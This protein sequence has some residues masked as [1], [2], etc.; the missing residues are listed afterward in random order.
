MFNPHTMAGEEKSEL[1][2][3]NSMSRL[4]EQ[5]QSEDWA[6]MGWPRTLSRAQSFLVRAPFGDTHASKPTRASSLL[7]RHGP[8]SLNRGYF[9]PDAEPLNRQFVYQRINEGS[10][11]PLQTSCALSTSNN[12]NYSTHASL[13]AAK[14][15]LRELAYESGTG[16]SRGRTALPVRS[17]SQQSFHLENVPEES[18]SDLSKGGTDCN[19]PRTDS[20]D[21][22]RAGKSTP[23]Q[24]AINMT[25]ILCGSGL[26]ALPYAT[27]CTSGYVGACGLLAM[28][29]AGTLFTAKL[30]GSELEHAWARQP[31]RKGFPGFPDL[32]SYAFGR[33]GRIAVALAL[34]F[35]LFLCL[36][37]FLLM[38][39]ANISATLDAI[40]GHPVHPVDADA[41][42]FTALATQLMTPVGCIWIMTAILVP[43][44]TFDDLTALSKFSAVGTIA[45]LALVLVVVVMALFC[46]GASE[47]LRLHNQ[48]N[49]MLGSN[50]DVSTEAERALSFGL[51]LFCFAGHAL[52]PSI[53][54]SLEN[55]SRHWDRVV[56][57]SYV[58]AFG[59]STVVACAGYA[60]FGNNVSEQISVD[61]G[62]VD[63]L[64]GAICC[65]LIA[66]SAI[67]KFALELHPLALGIEEFFVDDSIVKK[68]IAAQKVGLDD[69]VAC[70]SLL[71]KFISN[72]RSVMLRAT[73]L[74]LA[75]LCAILIPAFAIVASLLGAIFAT[76]ISLLFPCAVSLIH[77][78]LPRTSR[79]VC[80]LTIAVGTLVGCFGTWGA[81]MQAFSRN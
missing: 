33:S 38:G 3:D 11:L 4:S 10:D 19:L 56:N 28:A 29:S 21:V 59:A 18:S 61:V 41:S 79:Y 25:N 46:S 2:G 26:L 68:T 74:A 37:L 47:K 6:D 53:Y 63:R 45:T 72:N 80:F 9:T 1:G 77:G 51:V 16:K 39:G 31:G 7:R 24:A 71:S 14:A 40:R 44:T 67:S 23:L 20:D 32:A 50:S 57:I 75:L 35:D 43:A 5:T 76:G 60:L 62:A 48:N 69:N 36:V 42:L 17:I 13:L 73:V 66:I 12:A 22:A 49:S 65:T 34:Y 81:W 55:P 52:F 64:T 58:I 54:F 27:K 8:K 78:Q 70:F 30:L 15:S